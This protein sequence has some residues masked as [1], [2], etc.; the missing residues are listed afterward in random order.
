MSFTWNSINCET[1]G[2]I[3]EKYP[4]RPFP[5][6]KQTI[7]SIAGRSGDLIVDEDAFSNV[8]QEYEVFVGH[9]SQTMQEKL[10]AI[11]AWL[12]TPSG[13]CEL[14]DSYDPN[15]KRLARFVGGQQFLNSL[16]EFGR[17]TAVF[18]C[19]PQR[20]PITDVVYTPT[21]VELTPETIT[22]PSSGLLPSYPLIEFLTVGANTSF[23]VTDGNILI[24]VP[25]RAVAINRI[26]IDWE[27]QAVYNAYNGSVPSGTSITGIWKKVGDGDSITITI[28]T[29]PIPTVKIYPRQYAL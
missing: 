27:S 5:E 23:R 21:L 6:R 13:Y 25:S 3:V 19:K 17:A 18:D 7:Y 2:L 11:A 8:T 16:N 15:H 22:L 10:T 1:L 20:F 29:S 26:V 24:T 4:S 12:L 28:E 14:T 9:D